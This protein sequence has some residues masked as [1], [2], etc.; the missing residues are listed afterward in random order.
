M[1]DATDVRVLYV[2]VPRRTGPVLDCLERRRHNDT[3]VRH[4][5]GSAN[6]DDKSAPA[7]ERCGR[8][9]YRGSVGAPDDRGD[10]RR[11]NR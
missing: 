7:R 3:G 11:C 2:P 10:G 8:E 1:D 9:R 4:G 5:L 6:V